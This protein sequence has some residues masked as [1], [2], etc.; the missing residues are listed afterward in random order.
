MTDVIE[1]V[2][3]TKWYGKRRGIEEVDFSVREGEVFGFLGPNGAGKTTTIRLLLGFLSPTAGRATVFGLDTWTEAAA[4]HERVA[5]LGSDPGY[6]GELTAAEQ[7]DYMAELRRLPRGSWRRMAERLELDTSVRIRK[8]S[9]GN[10]QKIGVVAAFTGDAPLLILDEPTTGLD[11]LMQ[12]EFLSLVSEVRAAG[13]T[14]FLSSH[15]L[16]RGGARLR[17]GRD[18]P[19]GPPGRHPCRDRAARRAHALHQPVARRPGPGRDLRPPER[20]D[21][22]AHDPRGP[23]H[24]PR[25][26]QPAPRP[27]RRPRRRRHHDHDAGHRGRLPAP[28]PRPGAEEVAR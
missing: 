21:R 10:R 14:V 9:R 26:R 24:G 28:L 15:N 25:R 11:P 17:P 1:A 3:L 7:L 18:H 5:Y 6:L 4:V 12:R 27:D 19:R 2:G 16:H 20:R 23:P 8:L 22:G 13:R